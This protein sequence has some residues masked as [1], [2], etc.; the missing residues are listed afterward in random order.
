[1]NGSLDRDVQ[2]EANAGIESRL[3]DVVRIQAGYEGIFGHLLGNTYLI[4]DLTVDSA[5]QLS[6]LTQK[7]RLVTKSGAIFGPEFQI[8]FRKERFTPKQSVIARKREVQSLE[9][10][11]LTATQE[12]NILKTKRDN[13]TEESIWTKKEMKA[14]EIELHKIENE[15]KRADGVDEEL[16]DQERR[17]AEELIVLEQEKNHAIAEIEEINQKKTVLSER[18]SA[19]DSEQSRAATAL[20]EAQERMTLWEQKKTELERN[21]AE[22]K[23]NFKVIKEKQTDLSQ[24]SQFLQDQIKSVGLRNE[25]LERERE[26]AAQEIINLSDKLNAIARKKEVTEE[27]LMKHS[28]GVAR[29]REKRD[30]LLTVRDGFLKMNQRLTNKLADS[31]QNLNDLSLK[32][33]EIQ[34]AKQSISQELENRY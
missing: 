34:H 1:L 28:I 20:K 27:L 23:M 32:E 19:T 9:E 15:R 33:M 29:T 24:S 4:H 21:L 5:S 31:K 22:I 17:I 26:E 3:W 14:L 13:L 16:D 30:A 18:L 12:L 6:A 25:S 8:T 10:Q 7:T 2:L 11:L